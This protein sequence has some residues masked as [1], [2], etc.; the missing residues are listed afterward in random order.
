MRWWAALL[1]PA[2]VAAAC[3]GHGLYV[4]P[5]LETCGACG[6]SSARLDTRV[7]LIGDTGEG[8]PE[9]PVLTLL[10]AVAAEAADR[11]LVVFLGDNV[12]P[13]GVPAEA[14]D[15]VEQERAQAEAI[16][17]LWL[18]PVEAAGAE[19]VFLPGNHDWRRGRAG[20]MARLLE[21]ERWL[22]DNAGRP[23][24]VRM[25]PGDACP[26]PV[27]LDRGDSVRVVVAD[28]QW[29]L[30]QDKPR[31]ESCRWGVPG[32]MRDL[33]EASSA[34]PADGRATNGDFYAAL[35]AAVSGAGN[36]QV[37]YAAHHP[38]QTEGPHGGYFSGRDMFFPLTHLRGWLYLPIPL[39]YPI[40]RYGVTRHPQ[41][42]GNASYATMI[43][44]TE[45]ALSA[46]PRPVIT[47]AGHEHVLQ[48]FRRPDG[49]VYVVSGAGAKRDGVGKSEE[50]LFKHGAIGLMAV[51][52]FS[53]GR[54][55]LRVLEPRDNAP[56]A[57][58]FAIWV[59]DDPAE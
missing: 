32:A 39:L 43:E 9:N 36:R 42:V 23:E 22:A 51:D 3:T 15:D 21:Q 59:V 6:A 5:G 30:G 34:D 31:G 29:L 44:A 38:L 45:A 26:G 24:A 13:Q 35:E 46:A 7:V 53:D 27:I 17:R 33:E 12:Y 4:R 1:L 40:A 41:D 54:V 8:D 50:T 56:A 47:A 55:L 20:G 58:V 49:S 10:E 14:E 28:S 2:I 18:E 57:E 52:Y 25:L 48:V 11:T 19:T 37:L 16:L